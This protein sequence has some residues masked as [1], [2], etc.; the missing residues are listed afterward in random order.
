CRLFQ[1]TWLKN[2]GFIYDRHNFSKRESFTHKMR[3]GWGLAT[4][5][6]ILFGSDGTSKLYQ[7]DPISLEVTKTVTVKYQDNDVS[8]IN[9]LE[10]I[11]GEVWANVWQTD[12]IA[13]VSH[14]DGQVASWILLHELRQQL[15]NSGNTEIDV[16]NG[17]AWDEENDRLFGKSFCT[18]SFG[19]WIK[20]SKV[21]GQLT[22]P[23]CSQ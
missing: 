8:Y 4:D 14:E 10:Y 19:P 21:L 2:D 16:L 23:L 5:G 11:N 6:K 13:R 12:C 18:C 1:V 17:I 3:D 7:L 15:W 22:L 20:A 9:E